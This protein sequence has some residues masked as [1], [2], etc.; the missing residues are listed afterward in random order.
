MQCVFKL[1]KPKNQKKKALQV[2]RTAILSSKYGANNL[3]NFI[4]E[5]HSLRRRT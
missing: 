3:G 1:L 2:L 5:F 4:T